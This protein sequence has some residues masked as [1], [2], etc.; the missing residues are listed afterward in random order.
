MLRNN[1]TKLF[2]SLTSVDCPVPLGVVLPKNYYINGVPLSLWDSGLVLDKKGWNKKYC[3]PASE[4]SCKNRNPFS[5]NKQKIFTYYG[6][7]KNIP[8]LDCQ[9][10]ECSFALKLD[11]EYSGT[12]GKSTLLQSQTEAKYTTLPAIHV[13]PCCWSPTYPYSPCVRV[14]VPPTPHPWLFQSKQ[15]EKTKKAHSLIQSWTYPQPSLQCCHWLSFDVISFYFLFPY[16]LCI[17]RLRKKESL[18][19][20]W[21]L[22]VKFQNIMVRRR[23]LLMPV[24]LKI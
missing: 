16:F 9:R 5:V 12:W 17:D 18:P 1:N 4:N 2:C 6:L 23:L 7:P 13:H 21:R 3:D 19:F 24:R 22:L 15:L 20:P 10:Y 8:H 14:G 11:Q